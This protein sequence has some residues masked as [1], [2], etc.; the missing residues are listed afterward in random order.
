MRVLLSACDDAGLVDPGE[1]FDKTDDKLTLGQFPQQRHLGGRGVLLVRVSGVLELRSENTLNLGT[2]IQYI[3]AYS[4]E[5]QMDLLLIKS[6][7]SCS[8]C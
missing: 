2:I 1:I 4:A 8:S 5:D 7:I 3:L 6:E